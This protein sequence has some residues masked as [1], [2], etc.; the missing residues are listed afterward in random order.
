MKNYFS[1]MDDTV[2]TFSDIE[3][4]NGFDEITVYFE[5]PN[6]TGF[7]F[8]EGR[9][10]DNLFYKSFGFSED[11]L[12]QLEKYLRNNAPLIWEIANEKSGEPIA[13]T[14]A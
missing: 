9:L 7:D 8:A 3:E 2:L 5:R 11:E 13:K 4:R 1:T 14:I 10:P 6:E 12:L